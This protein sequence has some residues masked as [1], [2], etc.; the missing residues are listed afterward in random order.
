L[1]VVRGAIGGIIPSTH[2]E[3]RKF[4]CESV[5]GIFVTEFE[6]LGGIV[7][8]IGT[9]KYLGFVINFYPGVNGTCR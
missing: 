5:A 4:P 7:Y 8:V 9:K 2:T 1:C 6:V 3:D